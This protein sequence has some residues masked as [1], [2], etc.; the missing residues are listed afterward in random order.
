M[1]VNEKIKDFIEKAKHEY[2]LAYTHARRAEDAFPQTFEE[3]LVELVV[4]E[5]VNIHQQEWYD[6]NN[7]LTHEADTARDIGLRIGAK[8]QTLRLIQLIKHHFGI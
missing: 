7:A 4:R 3:K 6:R 8:S 5:I 1:A 2:E